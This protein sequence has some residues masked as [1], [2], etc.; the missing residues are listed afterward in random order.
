MGHKTENSGFICENCGREVPPVTNG[1]YR[2][3]CP[4]CLCSKHVDI[5]PGDRL[6][7]CGGV[8]DAVGVVYK[9]GKG[10]QLIHRCRKCGYESRNI[11]AE[12]TASPDVRELV[13]ELMQR[14][15][16]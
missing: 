1:S 12:D 9:S 8:M 6:S 13:I 16:L 7:G 2:N 3:H 10:F 15:L 11:V 14:N 5:N 4:F